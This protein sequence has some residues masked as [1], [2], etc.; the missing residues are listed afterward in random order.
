MNGRK[1][2]TLKYLETLEKP[3]LQKFIK[4][5]PNQCLLFLCE[6]IY[7][8]IIGNVPI[9]KAYIQPFEK[10]ARL[11]CNKKSNSLVR[12]KVLSSTTGI[13]LLT[14]IIKPCIKYLQ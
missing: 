13:K 9:D 11:L 1:L 10:E 5:C 6:C 2:D 3:E 14:N 12:R 8:I 7:N 4:S